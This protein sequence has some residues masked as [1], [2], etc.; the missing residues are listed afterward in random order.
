MAVQPHETVWTLT[1]AAVASR[2]LHVIAELGVADHVQDEPVA[3]KDLALQ[4]DADP[5]ALDRLL[6]LLAAHGIFDYRSGAYTHTDP[7]RLLRSDHPM[8]MRAF[9]RMIGTPGFQA[10]FAALEHSARTGSP[11]VEV[12]DP[13]GLWNYLEAHPVE[14]A[15][16][17]AAMTAKA[18]ADIGAV[19]SSYDFSRFRTIA[20]IGGGRGHL[21]SAIVDAAP[22]AQGIL[23][24]LPAVIETLALDSGRL[25]TRPGDFFVDALPA[26]DAYLLMEVIHD[27]ADAEASAILS[28]IHDAASPGATVL[29]IEGVV[30]EETPDPRVHTLDVI[31]LAMT[32]G[33][34]RSGSQLGELLNTSGFDLIRVLETPGAMRI[35]EAT[36]R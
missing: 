8:S 20:D 4:C 22:E 33:R 26:A 13:K 5:E 35:V 12:V 34:E 9:P 3:V 11:A 32:G 19:V 36:A 2:A 28:A 21:L 24:D 29:I 27:W 17:G 15:I 31:M 1:T 7:S 30:G 23:F 6:R 10:S 14:A 18:L 16:F 25:A